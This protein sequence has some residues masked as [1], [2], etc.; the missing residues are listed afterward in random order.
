MDEAELLFT[1]ILD[2]DRLSLY[3]DRDRPLG[4]DKSGFVSR[5]LKRRISGEPLQYILGEVEFMGLDFKVT[6]DVFIPRP[7][8]EV[9]VETILKQI[10][11]PGWGYPK[12]AVLD[13]GTGS[14]CIAISLAKFLNNTKITATDISERA[15]KI[16]SANAALNRGELD[17]RKGNL[18]QDARL[19]LDSYDLIVS[20]PP[21]IPSGEFKY[22]QPEIKFEPSIALDGGSDGLDFYRRIIAQS[23][24][25]LKGGGLLIMEIG[26]R[27]AQAIK[28][29]LEGSLNF[30]IMAIVKDYNNMDRVV[31]AK[32]TSKNG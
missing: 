27:Q 20:N 5:V 9:L 15:L 7:E 31:V 16:A 2:S 28:D 24:L 32:R 26:L 13:L 23:P 8:T 21:Y 17:F 18:F 3:L 1:H 14:G 12:T 25:Y 30:A 6:P 11:D 22:L 10:P 29:I 19:E 4:K